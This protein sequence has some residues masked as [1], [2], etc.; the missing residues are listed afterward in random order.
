MCGIGGGIG[1]REDPIIARAVSLCLDLNAH[2]GPD[3]RAERQVSAGTWNAWFAHNRLAIVD[4]TPGGNQPMT[5]GT[6]WISYNGEIY[7][8]IELRRELEATGSRF[9]STSDTEVLLAAWNMWG[10]GCLDRLNGFFAFALLDLA[11]RQ[12]VLVRDRFGVKPLHYHATPERVLFASTAT[13]LARLVG[14]EPDLGY[15]ARGVRFGAWDDDSSASPYRQVR[16]VPAGHLAVADLGADSLN[17]TVRPW[18]RL[19]ERVSNLVPVLAALSPEAA[20]TRARELLTDAVRL[21]LRADVPVAVSLSGGVDSATISALARREEGRLLGFSY[22]HPDRAETEG[23]VIAAI[24]ESLGMDVEY[25]WPG[26]AAMADMFWECLDAQDAP[27]AGASVVAQF[28]V[29]RAVRQAK[30]K[31]LLGGQGGDE[32]F[33]GYR[34]Y[35]AW[36]W[37]AAVKAGHPVNAVSTGVDLA[38][39]LWA[40]RSQWRTYVAAARR[41]RGGDSGTLLRLPEVPSPEHSASGV[42]GLAARQVADIRSGGLPTLLRYEDRNSMDNSVESRLPFLDYRLVEWGIAAPA[43]T[44]L[45]NGLGKWM[46]R[47]VAADTLPAVVTTTREKRGFDVDVGEWLASG[48]GDRIRAELERHRSAIAEVL[49][50]A[51]GIGSAFSNAALSASPRRLSDAITALWLARRQ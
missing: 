36:Q 2:R 15:L 9:H 16:A 50:A 30:V 21:R 51:V 17:L 29:F 38:R 37:L 1:R 11:R 33:M 25:V 26:A 34:K 49:P 13:P 12:L 40:Q 5:D 19:A 7:N 10:E 22:G 20:V 48:L 27:F 6:A 46:L 31:V 35:L 39:G 32:V 44:K 18:Y 41:Y 3:H 4:L 8:Y 43:Q 42:P 47:Q 23:P 28:A 24:A 14:T 45:R